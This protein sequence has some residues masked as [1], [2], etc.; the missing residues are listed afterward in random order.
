MK[1]IRF[2]LIFI[3]ALYNTSYIMAI[4]EA[5]NPPAQPKAEEQYEH[6]PDY[7]QVVDEYRKYLI[8]V[9]DYVKEEIHEFRIKVAEINKSKKELYKRL[10]KQA[11]DYLKK[12]Q[13]YKKKLPLKVRKKLEK[14]DPKVESKGE[15]VK[16]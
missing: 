5:K 16:K 7:D 9:P 1:F 3:L 14:R 2:T 10:S 11:Q 4:E 13:K 12:E 8:N 6:N 15:E